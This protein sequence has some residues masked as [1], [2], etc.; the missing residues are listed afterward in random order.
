MEQTSPQQTLHP[1][2]GP[3]D[4]PDPPNDRSQAIPSCE[5]RLRIVPHMGSHAM[6]WD[7]RR[8][9]EKREAVGKEHRET[10]SKVIE[11]QKPTAEYL[12]PHRSLFLGWDLRQNSK[13]KKVKNSQYD[14]QKFWCRKIVLNRFWGQWV[15]S[16]NLF[17]RLSGL[18]W[19]IIHYENLTRMEFPLRVNPWKSRI[20]AA[21]SLVL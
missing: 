8:R 3:R 21:F 2:D 9:V 11:R 16:L 14:N 6:R 13:R 12:P 1:P 4:I 15:Q 18:C 19:E 7:C 20:V 17:A 5:A 10:L